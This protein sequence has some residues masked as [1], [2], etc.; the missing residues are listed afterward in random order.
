MPRDIEMKQR[1]PRPEAA[2]VFLILFVSALLY[3]RTAWFDFTYDDWVIVARNPVVQ[4]WAGLKS[5]LLSTYW[6]GLTRGLYRPVTVLSFA[7][8]RLVHG[9]DPAGFHLFNLLLHAVVAV[10]VYR[11]ALQVT[12]SRWAAIVGG[13]LFASHPIHIEAVAGVVG[14]AELLSALFALAAMLVWMRHSNGETKSP[15]II[16]LAVLYLLACASKENVTVVPAIL[17]L[18]EASRISVGQVRE[19]VLALVCDKRIWALAAA[20]TASLALRVA[21]MGGAKAAFASNPPFVENPL[22][23]EPA[24]VRMWSAAANQVLGV[25][26]QVFPYRLLPDYSYLTLV[27]RHSWLDPLCVAAVAIA[28]AA[29]SLWF[30]PRR[31]TRQLAFF[32]GWYVIA[33][34]PTS[35]ILFAIGTVFGERLLYFPSVAFC[36][37]VG[38]VVDILIGRFLPAVGLRRWAVA[39]VSIPILVMG[40]ATSIHLPHWRN[41]YEL[42]SAA[43]AA[44]P[45]NVKARLW[46]GDAL[47]RSGDFAAAIRE[48]KRAIEIL[49]QY[50]APYANL[51]VPLM[52][53]QR[54]AEAVEAGETALRLMETEN[55]ELVMN[56][57]M[58][59]MESG[60]QVRFLEYTQR[61]LELDPGSSRA[62]YQLARY[63]LREGNRKAAV[64]HLK[65][66]LR[67]NPGSAEAP[68]IR[69]LLGG[70]R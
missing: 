66:S 49:P 19:R 47:V 26:L 21:V 33:I 38:L 55:A 67:I 27:P 63:Y 70:S 54:Y 43:V 37:G 44:A 64:E 51:M 1:T 10:L 2:V 13:L 30:T 4:T 50:G 15:R 46:Y 16:Q 48:Y 39:G 40:I 9:G 68:I 58:A 45:D 23:H 62:H 29:L 8:E 18:W 35:N 11:V 36:I 41:D 32:S 52:E 14:R 3:L 24:V 6:P 65:E 57:A 20:G 60:D 42:F 28:A 59:C 31:K 7:L 22:A 69:K 34:A 56:L 5:T 17:I 25:V 12:C 61:A 53:Q